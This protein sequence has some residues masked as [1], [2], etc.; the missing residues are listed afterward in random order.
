[1]D[2]K[3]YEQIN[4]SLSSSIRMK[5][6]NIRNYLS[7]GNASVM[8]GA[9][10]SRNADMDETVSMKDWNSLAKVFYHKLYSK[11]PNGDDLAFK[12]PMRLASL[13]ETS[14]GR[15]E[16]D[17]MIFE[18]L[19]DERI[20]P[21]EIHK[22]LLNLKWKDVFTTNYDRLLENAASFSE[23]HYNVVTNKE[24][25]I[26]TKSPRIVK[27]HG[28]FPDIHPF[29]MT[30]EDY[31]T[32]P[33]K[34]PEF[35]N[36][37]RQALIENVFCLIGFSGDDPNFLNWIGWLRD[38]M[39]NLS[40]PIYLIT[41]DK[42]FHDAES[43]LLKNRKLDV[44]N[45]AEVENIHGYKEAF[46]FLFKYLGEQPDENI[47]GDVAVSLKLEDINEVKR[48]T[49]KAKTIRTTYPGWLLMPLD[50]YERFRDCSQEFPFI[51]KEVS[52]IT[53]KEVR[54]RFLYELNWRLSISLTP[55]NVNWYVE[56]LESISYDNTDSQEVMLMKQSLKISLLS[57]YRSRLSTISFNS[58]VDAI[59]SVKDSL[60]IELKRVYYYER[61]LMAVSFMD[62]PKAEEILNKW[63]VTKFDYIGSI[64]RSVILLEIGKRKEAIELLNETYQTIRSQLV[65]INDS[66]SP[67]LN[68]CRYQI[69]NLLTIL[70]YDKHRKQDKGWEYS[71]D[72]NTI[73]EQFKKKLSETE[74]D[75]RYFEYHDFNIG[76]RSITWKG[77]SGFATKYLYSYRCVRLYEKA[78]FPFGLPECSINVNSQKRTM[79]SFIQYEFL[80]CSTILIRGCCEKLISEVL[81]RSN[82]NNITRKDADFLFDIFYPC[83]QKYSNTDNRAVIARLKSIA[84]LLSFVSVKASQDN[85]VPLS[86]IIHKWGNKN[87]QE[88]I[89]NV[90][91]K[92][93]LSKIL[94]LIYNLPITTNEYEDDL[95]IPNIVDVKFRLSKQAIDIM[96]AGITSNS[97]NVNDDAYQRIAST[98]QNMSKANKDRFDKAIRKWR[99]IEIKTLNMLRSYNLT[100]FSPNDEEKDMNTIC[101]IEVDKFI[102]QDY[103]YNQSSESIS[104]INRGINRLIP[105]AQYLNNAQKADVLKKILDFL[106]KNEDVLK[107]NDIKEFFGGLR[108]FSNR[109]MFS[110]Q[111]FI[112]KLNIENIDNTILKSMAEIIIKYSKYDFRCMTILS[113]LNSQ[114]HRDDV[115]ELIKGSLFQNDYAKDNDVLTA[116]YR[117]FKIKFD[118]QIFDKIL[119]YISFASDTNISRYIRFVKNVIE[120]DLIPEQYEPHIEDALK[121][122]YHMTDRKDLPIESLMEMEYETI[123]LVDCLI[124]KHPKFKTTKV[125]KKWIEFNDNPDIF[126]DIRLY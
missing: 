105:L 115:T 96:Y 30:E 116:L 39:G 73:Y 1:M 63:S 9:G 74:N 32:Y 97:K 13:I 60:P 45:F 26:Y 56:E 49:E 75:K 50:Y 59:D 85:I 20:A 69:E 80:Y 7:Y 44:I 64:W 94:P 71:A 119:Y 53:D 33:S 84:T 29:I 41:Y 25:L 2:T 16:L 114:L 90:L 123:R 24:T 112:G 92:D 103:V 61:A 38:V 118:E 28:S 108:S 42:T 117:E 100:P 22:S 23:R 121:R 12:T 8:I 65:I 124:K 55:K 6:D 3:V 17:K 110:L 35:V 43:T 19:P 82:L 98:Y 31:R 95:R 102:N 14:F 72:F 58:L 36:T 109:F 10:F 91:T 86:K 125:V 93:S 107:K 77:G 68:S 106:R 47:W 5:L 4:S 122:L 46:D 87:N 34:Y 54:L 27:L 113:Y 101:A 48:T 126:N 89:Y 11:T 104:Q 78:G 21:G 111:H 99:D 52:N 66:Y 40:S 67:L 15:K 62:Y 57:I 88:T 18:S 83:F 76:R 81:N 51:G 79:D 70:V 37:V 120:Y